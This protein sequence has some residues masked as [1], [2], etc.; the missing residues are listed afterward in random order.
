MYTLQKLQFENKSWLFVRNV[1][2]RA[3]IEITDAR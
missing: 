2:S 3:R 1:M